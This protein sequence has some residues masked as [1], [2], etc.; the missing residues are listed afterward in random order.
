[1]A[2]DRAK[3]DAAKEENRQKGLKVRAESQAH[4]AASQQQN[5]EWVAKGKELAARD[6]QQ[7]QRI[8]DVVGL[9]SKRVAEIT[10]IAK[11]E[12]LDFERNLRLVRDR[13]RAAKNAEAA[14]VRAQL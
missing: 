12:E 6:R 10:A 7:K 2:K 8:R 11:Q 9:Q 1:M 5:A 14:S 4:R 3:M 13:L